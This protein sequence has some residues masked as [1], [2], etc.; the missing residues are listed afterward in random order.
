MSATL[1]EVLKGPR[2]EHRRILLGGRAESGV[3][4]DDG[5]LQLEDGRV[6]DLSDAT[7]LPPCEP[8]KIICVHLSYRSRG[9]ESRNSPRFEFQ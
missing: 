3:V 7:H 8:T 9:I 6:V 4:R 2:V 1:P 5:R